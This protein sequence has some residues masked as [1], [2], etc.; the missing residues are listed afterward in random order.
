MLLTAEHRKR[1]E[2]RGVDGVVD[3][4]TKAK[5][6]EDIQMPVVLKGDEDHVYDL[7]PLIDYFVLHVKASGKTTVKHPSP[8]QARSEGVRLCDIEALTGEG[9]DEENEERVKLVLSDFEAD[10]AQFLLEGEGSPLPS[11]TEAQVNAEVAEQQRQAV[12]PGEEWKRKVV[13]LP[14]GAHA[15]LQRV[16]TAYGANFK[17]ED[18][19]ALLAAIGG[20][21][22][23]HQEVFVQLEQL[24][25][26]NAEIN[27]ISD[28]DHDR[29]TRAYILNP[30]AD[31]VLRVQRREIAA[32]KLV[33]EWVGV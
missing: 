14:E 21:D 3:P 13:V 20:S 8:E 7:E 29:K 31:E 33:S 15:F 9:I 19:D 17:L 2:E 5:K 26:D 4:L 18:G 27:L 6:L 1:L 11:L 16:E 10:I 23:K 32:Q 25:D 30:D 24:L 28:Y 12:M 22:D